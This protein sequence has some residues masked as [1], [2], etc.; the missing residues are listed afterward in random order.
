MMVV[1]VLLV[2]RR[3]LHRCLFMEEEPTTNATLC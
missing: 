1:V 3:W 2:R